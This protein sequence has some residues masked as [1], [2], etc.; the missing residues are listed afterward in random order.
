MCKLKIKGYNKIYHENT[1]KKH[2]YMGQ[3]DFRL[4]KISRNKEGHFKIK[5]SVH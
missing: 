2:E 4:R 3:V 5:R 1:N